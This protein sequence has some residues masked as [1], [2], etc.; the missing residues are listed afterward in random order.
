MVGPS[1]DPLLVP[2]GDAT[3]AE[4]VRS[5]LDLHL[6]A[7]EDPDVVHPHLSR[8]VGEDLVAVL[9][10]DT[11]HRVGEGFDDRPLDEDRVVLGLGYG[12]PP[13]VGARK[14]GARKITVG[15]TDEPT[16]PGPLRE[17][18]EISSPTRPGRAATRPTPPSPLRF[19][20]RTWP[21]GPG[22]PPGGCH[23]R[24]SRGGSD[25]GPGLRCRRWTSAPAG[26]TPGRPRP[27]TAPPPAGRGRRRRSRC[28]PR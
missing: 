1:L 24:R 15:A 20:P 11:E 14:R 25:S 22:P 19:P 28:P 17:I 13:G 5:E 6:V 18:A 23:R 8:D 12:T 9:E 4:V 10:L 7:G 27:R 2:V 21:E 3:S 16:T 26:S